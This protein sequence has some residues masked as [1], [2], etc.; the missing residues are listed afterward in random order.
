M[1]VVATARPVPF[2]TRGPAP[3][4]AHAAHAARAMGGRLVIH[5]AAGADLA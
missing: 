3:A 2:E 1:A 5:V 4:L